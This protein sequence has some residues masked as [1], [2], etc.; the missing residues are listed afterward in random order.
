MPDIKEERLIY[1]SETFETLHKGDHLASVLRVVKRYGCIPD[2]GY[3]IQI[4]STIPINAGV[5]SSSALVVAWTHFLL[6]TFGSDR[7]ITP[8]LIAQ[9]AYEAEVLE[10]NSPG[11]KM[12]QYTIALGHII[13]L[14]TG[15]KFSYK[16]IGADLNGLALGVSGIPK[17]TIG[18]LGELRVKAQAAISEVKTKEPEFDL[19]TATSADA[20]KLSNVVSTPLKPYFIAAIKNHEITQQALKTFETQPLD[21]QMIGKLMSKHHSVLKNLLKI[22]VPLIDSMIDAAIDAGAYGAKIVGS[23][24]G[25]SIIALAP[26]DRIEAVVDAIKISGAKDAYEVKVVGGSDVR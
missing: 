20:E 18:V 15:S 6:E 14:D 21:L 12:D 10:H 5:S 7:E 4:K 17:Q 8:T 26:Q 25:G 16:T 24:G 19:K 22:T 23:G 9:L 11:G 2:K 1:I 13:Y 3:D